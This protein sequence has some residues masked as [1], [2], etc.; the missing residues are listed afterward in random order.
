MFV[1]ALV[2]YVA[3]LCLQWP[4]HNYILQPGQEVWAVIS[5]YIIDVYVLVSLIKEN[6]FR[7]TGLNLAKF[8]TLEEAVCML[9]VC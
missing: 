4:L 7:L 3:P 5:L 8:L 1:Y 6:K 9:R 2:Q